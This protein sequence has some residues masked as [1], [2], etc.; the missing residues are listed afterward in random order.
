VTDAEREERAVWKLGECGS[1]VTRAAGGVRDGWW[2][3]VDRQTAI[4]TAWMDNV[5]ALV[6][7]ADAIYAAH[8]TTRRITPSA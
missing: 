4:E 5:I 2:I 3:V 1:D 8:R 7:L 6:E